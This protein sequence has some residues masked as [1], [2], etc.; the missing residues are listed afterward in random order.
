LIVANPFIEFLFK[1][2]TDKGEY[3]IN[4][5]EIKEVF[6]VKDLTD[7]NLM[8]DVRNMIQENLKYIGVKDLVGEDMISYGRNISKS[9][10]HPINKICYKLLFF[11]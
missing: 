10:C 11:K 5:G 7:N 1:Y 9:F 8:S 3:R 6:E 4:K 2:N